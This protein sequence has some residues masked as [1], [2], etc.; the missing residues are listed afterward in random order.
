[1]FR[2]SAAKE[3]VRLSSK[4]PAKPML[5]WA[6]ERL[7]Q[8]VIINLVSNAVK[9]TQKGGE[10]N[11]TVEDLGAEGCGVYIC[12]TGIGIENESIQM[13]VEPFVQVETALSR[14]NGGAGLGLPLVKKIVELHDGSLSIESEI[15]VG[16]RVSAKFPL[17]RLEKARENAAPISPE[18]VVSEEA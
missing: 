2:D 13:I 15:G 9:F 7:L 14:E 12:D 6:D 8:Q 3:G 18:I 16:T 1:M 11:V 5:I 4:M 17:W 10:V